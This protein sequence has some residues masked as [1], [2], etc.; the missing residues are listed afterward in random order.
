V[1]DGIILIYSQYI[2][3][4][5]IPMA[6]SLEEMGFTRYGADGTRPLFRRTKKDGPP[7][8]V[9]VRTM[10]HEPPADSN[11]VFMPARYAMITGDQRLS[12]NNEFE[13]KGLTSEG[14]NGGD[15]NRNGHKVKVVLISKA[16]SEGIDFKF[17][18]QVHI[19]DPWYNMNR[20][21][22]ITG[23]AVRIFSHKDLPFEKRNVQIFMH[24]TILGENREEA[25]DLYI[26]RVAEYKAIQIG[27]ITRLLK[28]TAV[29]CIINHGQTN[30]TQEMMTNSLKAPITQTLSNHM[31]LRDFKIGDAPFSPTCDYMADCSFSCRP[32]KLIREDELNEDTYSERFILINAEKILQRIRLLMRFEFF[33]KKDVLIRAIRT[34]KEYPIIQIYA[35]LTQL[36]NDENEVIMDKY[37]RNGRLVNIG[38][39]YLF[40]PLE[41]RN[42][43]ASIFERSVPIDY[44]FNMVEF[45][46]KPKEGQQN[47]REKYKDRQRQQPMA[48][49]MQ[50]QGQEEQAEP[51]Q[52][53]E[54]RQ[55]METASAFTRENRVPRGDQDWYK[56]CGI[57]IRF[58]T[59]KYPE[60]QPYLVP[61]VVAHMM[62]LLSFEEKL[63][64]MNYLYKFKTLQKGSLEWFAKSYI[65]TN[66]VLTEQSWN[67]FVM[68]KGEKRKFMILQKD[69]RVWVEATPMQA[70]ALEKSK[71]IEETVAFSLDRLNPVVGYIGYGKKNDVLVF[72]TRDILS[73]RDTGARCDEAGKAEVI[74]IL[75]KIL[76][77]TVYTNE[78]TKIQKDAEGNMIQDA[79]NVIELC[80]LLEFL[81]RYSEAINKNGL[82]WFFTPEMAVYIF[83]AIGK[84]REKGKKK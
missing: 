42:K 79:I 5:L 22:Q 18:R 81:L 13:L 67:V 33:Y 11:G 43:N 30:F 14:E 24:G 21:E 75:N 56:H 40:Q 83:T 71:A 57:V 16:G 63:D 2:D 3:S 68:Y 15:G 78:N 6:L 44:K 76:G 50:E 52:I 84:T 26:Y 51:S 69:S 7:S 38:E 49:G 36:V 32:N 17:I 23:R 59:Q 45:Q 53:T 1:S 39:Y 77:E 66:S 58:M 47:I 74:K 62:E 61:F 48:E 20:S 10:T 34:Q 27:K 35:A 70:L 4:G 28:E 31:V 54:M 9:D 72:K 8:V 29:D 65:E 73:S 19:L 37:G 80:I 82:Q 55:N 41:L 46:L 25:A 12:P 64:V 60:S